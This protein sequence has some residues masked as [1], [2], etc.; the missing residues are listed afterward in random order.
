MTTSR[1]KEDFDRRIMELYLK[2]VQR[3]LEFFGVP[4]L[5][6]HWNISTCVCTCMS[7]LDEVY[8]A[9]ACI[10]TSPLMTELIEK[11]LISLGF[12]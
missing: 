7:L 3:W 2:A 4:A 8:Q 11:F 5:P 1:K 10:H 9:R 12:Y 6:C